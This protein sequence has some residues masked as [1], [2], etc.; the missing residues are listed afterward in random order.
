MSPE[1]TGNPRQCTNVFCRQSPLRLPQR[2]LGTGGRCELASPPGWPLPGL[3]QDGGAGQ[4]C[5]LGSLRDVCNL[6]VRQPDRAAVVVLR[7]AATDP[8]AELERQVGAPIRV[9]CF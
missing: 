3:E 2:D 5:A 9:D 7:D 8:P 6:D 4:A 1:A